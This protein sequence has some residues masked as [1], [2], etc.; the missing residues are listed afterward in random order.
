MAE[1]MINGIRLEG[2][3]AFA[4]FQCLHCG[5]CEE[6]CQ[7]HLPLRD[8]YLVLED[9]L[10]SRFGSPAETVWDFIHELDSRREFVR[11]IFGLDLPEWSP[12]ESL[13]RVP[14]VERSTDGGNV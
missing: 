5:L 1:A 4:S 3:E 8:C 13:T 10:E 12:E 9:W 14:K 7:T 2:S 11:D 6:V